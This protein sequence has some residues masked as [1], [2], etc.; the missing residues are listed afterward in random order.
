M[1]PLANWVDTV[2]FVSAKNTCTATHGRINN[3]MCTVY[4]CSEAAHG[5]LQTFHSFWNSLWRRKEVRL[6]L[7]TVGCQGRTD[8]RGGI[9]WA[10]WFP[11]RAYLQALCFF[12][13]CHAGSVLP[14]SL[15]STARM[16]SLYYSLQI[17]YTVIIV[18]NCKH[19]G[20]CHSC[21]EIL[22]CP[23]SQKYNICPESTKTKGGFQAVH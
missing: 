4:S 2:T 8:G 11:A 6:S 21:H 18:L 7:Q 1:I 12:P 9:V 15:A 16:I 17:W 19:F 14:N 23:N 22:F 5:H 3:L 13:L 20:C 10:R